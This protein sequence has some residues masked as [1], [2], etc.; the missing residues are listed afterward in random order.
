MMAKYTDKK[1]EQSFHKVKFV[2]KQ[3]H[4]EF[5]SVLRRIFTFGEP[6]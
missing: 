4:V 3:K 1:F 5:Q 6:G 2:F